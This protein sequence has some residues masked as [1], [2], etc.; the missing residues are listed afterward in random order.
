MVD[1]SPVNF[2]IIRLL[3]FA[4]REGGDEFGEKI[5]FVKNE[6]VKSELTLISHFKK[7]Q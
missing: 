4:F 6:G 5:P 1:F 7:C 2:E 3:G